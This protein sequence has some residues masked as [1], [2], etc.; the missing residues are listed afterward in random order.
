MDKFTAMRTFRKVVECGGFAAA[1]RSLNLSNAAV[2][3]HVRDLEEALGTALL[4][5]TTRKVSLTEPGRAYFDRCVRILDE[6]DDVERSLGALQAAP[7]GLLRVNAP[8]AM[9]VTAFAPAIARFGLRHPEVKVNLVLNDRTVDMV[10]EGFDVSL[11]VRAALPDSSLIA[12]RLCTM[13]LVLSGSPDYL[14]RAGEPATP[15]DLAG[16]RTLVYT[17]ATEPGRWT[18]HKDGRAI[19]HVP[20]PV[21]STNSSLALRHGVLEGLGLSIF[22]LCYIAADLATGRLRRL[23]ADH[24]IGT[25]AVHA[26]YP[27]GRHLSPK[28]RAF[29]DFMAAAFARP[30]WEIDHSR[31]AND[32]SAEE[33]LQ[34]EG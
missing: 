9:G 20:D 33:R 25:V 24:D 29:V 18:F 16:H 6:I 34:P 19:V 4:V 30:P 28:V 31:I 13:P 15:D 14:A 2:S 22:P 27:S 5:R 11:R 23:M 10:E 32:P 21:L 7:R 12:R 17:L 26:V 8:M 3:C 1:A